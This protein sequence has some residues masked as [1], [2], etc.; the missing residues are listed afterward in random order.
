M[1]KLDEQAKEAISKN[2]PAFV[3]TVNLSGK[4][5]VSA[6][7]S[8]SVLDDENVIFADIFSPRTSANIKENPQVSIICLGSEG[9][10]AIRIWGKA[11]VINSGELFDA[12][13]EE[14]SQKNMKIN[15]LIKVF[16]DEIE[17]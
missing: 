15:N 6:K 12:I 13:S 5:N 4:P 8:L 1:T 14:Y 2:K 16:V 9:R 11:E 7:G 10:K 17:M 3:A